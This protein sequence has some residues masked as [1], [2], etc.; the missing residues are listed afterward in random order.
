MRLI[1]I[2]KPNLH[3]TSFLSRHPFIHSV[4]SFTT[5]LR[6]V[7][8]YHFA[9]FCLWGAFCIAFDFF[10]FEFP[11]YG[12]MFCFVLLFIFEQLRR[13]KEREGGTDRTE[14]RWKVESL[15]Y[16]MRTEWEEVWKG[17][18]EV[19][20][21]PARRGEEEMKDG[22]SQ[23]NCFKYLFRHFGFFHFFLK[24]TDRHRHTEQC[25]WFCGWLI[26]GYSLPRGMVC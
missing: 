22:G 18:T 21:R 19:R 16:A 1:Y 6:D 14:E 3:I 7:L 5:I 15:P 11:S 4:L 13:R 17:N 12:I 25:L 9:V 10:E 8:W 26:L 2:Y 24:K 23:A 20:G